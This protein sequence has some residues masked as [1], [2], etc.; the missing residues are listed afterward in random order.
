MSKY[1]VED[2]ENIVNSKDDQVDQPSVLE[3]AARGAVN[4]FNVAPTVV[5]GI[6]TIFNSK[7]DWV[8][9]EAWNQLSKG[10]KFDLLKNESDKKFRAAREAH[11][12]ADLVGNFGAGLLI[13]SGAGIGAKVA[14]SLGAKTVGKA[15]GSIAGS[16]TE[17]ALQ[18][19]AFADEGNKL[20]A[21]GLGASVGAGFGAGGKAL[22]KLI[23]SGKAANK[24]VQRLPEMEK[25]ANKN[26]SAVSKLERKVKNK[27][28][29][30][31]SVRENDAIKFSNDLENDIQSSIEK[32]QMKDEELID[33]T[34]NLK[35]ELQK[36]ISNESSEGWEALS[37]I[38]DISVK[39]YVEKLKEQRNK[40]HK[41]DPN[42]GRL[43][44]WIDV[45]E[46]YGDNKI[47][48]KELRKL[49]NGI[50]NDITETDINNYTKG[51]YSSLSS[52]ILTKLANEARENLAQ[53]NT[54][55]AD[56]VK[57]IGK[58]VKDIQNI[59]DV[60]KL[61]KEDGSVLRIMKQANKQKPIRDA[62]DKFKELT[63]VDL[64]PQIAE[65]RAIQESTNIPIKSS[66]DLVELISKS[67]SDNV[68]LKE[69]KNRLVQYD[70]VNG[71]DFSSRL[72]GYRNQYL[73]DLLAKAEDYIKE[74]T[75]GGSKLTKN[76]YNILAMTPYT[77]QDGIRGLLNRIGSE[78]TKKAQ[79]KLLS[80]HKAAKNMIKDLSTFS[81]EDWREVFRNIQNENL[82][83]LI[84]SGKANGSRRVQLGANVGS[85]INDWIKKIPV[86][87]QAWGAITGALIDSG[88]LQ[89]ARRELLDRMY[90][91]EKNPR[92]LFDINNLSGT[93]A[94]NWES[95]IA[96]RLLA[97]KISSE[98][99]EDERKRE[100]WNQLSTPINTTQSIENK[101]DQN[102]QYFGRRK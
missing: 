58:K 55:Y 57:D 12:V 90:Q 49:V 74:G 18:S 99:I 39:P 79:T 72:E 68:K 14:G 38:E 30:E 95:K 71:T 6:E 27:I 86:A 26:E 77:K 76:A 1:T 59:E 33:Q 61:N 84:G 34:R 11:P 80:Q 67:G 97:P 32:G 66:E 92:P 44:K 15:V 3:S 51:L 50:Y 35:K 5:G 87:G 19:A 60:L 75:K 48:E 24:Y 16:A 46:E 21:A 45:L 41:S 96:N 65:V 56:K 47:S 81:G 52:R 10:D 70:K 28:E 98:I 62:L 93:A 2:I 7:P 23:S 25:V 82:Y 102:E 40:L 42:S 17:G 91:L 8:S 100:A 85:G 73:I 78:D 4:Q 36:A 54:V 13:P 20:E 101:Q 69:L 37:D 29:E 63:G 22:G 94:S 88:R 9:E 89:R 53:K 31:K 43:D 83:D 64:Q